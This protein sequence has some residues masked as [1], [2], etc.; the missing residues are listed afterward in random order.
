MRRLE[1]GNVGAEG[2]NSGSGKAIQGRGV[3]NQ[4][5]ECME[6]LYENILSCSQI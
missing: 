1:K 4:D 5:E 2:G 6:K 3:K